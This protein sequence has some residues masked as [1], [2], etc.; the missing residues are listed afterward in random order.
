M[1][2]TTEV[3]ESKLEKLV[4]KLKAYVKEHKARPF[5]PRPK[6]SKL[7]VFSDCAGISAEI[8]L[9][10]LGLKQFFTIVGGSEIDEVKRCLIGVVHETCRTSCKSESFATDIFQRDPKDSPGA[11]IYLA[12][13]PCPAFSKMGRRFGLRDSKKRGI[14]LVA[15]LRYIAY[16]KPPV[17]LL[18]Q[19]TGFLE[20]KHWL[21]QKMLRKTFA[22]CGYTVRAK[23]LQTCDHGLPQSRPRL[24]VVALRNPI[25][26]FRFPKAWG[27]C[28]PIE[29]ILDVGKVGDEVL[30]LSKFGPSTAT[31]KLRTGYWILDVASS[32]R[33]TS[34]P[35][36]RVSPCLTRSRCKARGYYVPRLARRLSVE[37]FS[38]L[39]GIP[40][41]IC[42]NMVRKL[43][44]EHANDKRFTQARCE[45]EVAAAFGD[46]MSL[47]VLQ[48]V[49]SR[50]L[51]ASGLWPSQVTRTDFWASPTAFKDVDHTFQGEAAK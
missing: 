43:L 34:I 48:R 1:P 26:E 45:N 47:N 23:V 51:A 20:K 44:A 11:D 16:H 8:A 21:A 37:E 14:P 6:G 13:F 18:E 15:G 50:A 38:Q 29:S 25:A 33:F 12:G 7:R 4:G 17:V 24:W 2:R 35:K 19:V 31:E 5:Q 22:A 46:G 39:Q 36:H 3:A 41:S 30:D 10:L 9:T 32:A 27:K 42:R 40:V 49:L 28:P